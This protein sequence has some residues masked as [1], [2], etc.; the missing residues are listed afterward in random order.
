MR[1]RMS[2]RPVAAGALCLATTTGAAVATAAA[3]APPTAAPAAFKPKPRISVGGRSLEVR[4][5]RRAAVRGHVR[6]AAAGVR[7]ALQARRGTRWVTLD[8]GRTRPSGRYRLRDR[9]PAA[10]SARVRVRVP[11]GARVRAGHRRVGRMN[12]FRVAYASW[13]GPGLY[14]NSLGCGGRLG[15]GTVGV[16]H[17]TLPCGTKVTLRHAG[18]TVRV[19]VIDRGPYV[20]G[21]EYDLTAATARR[22]RFSGHGAILVTR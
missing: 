8:R 15:T 18:R 4:A 13:Y 17:K 6:P 3:Q 12:V 19:R 10:T 9:Q 14:G 21:R 20:A 11:G 22:L 2:A 7:V 1:L 5:G 16:A